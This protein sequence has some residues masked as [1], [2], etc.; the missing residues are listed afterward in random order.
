M[1]A[2]LE[3]VLERAGDDLFASVCD[4]VRAAAWD[5]A[6]AAKRA[7]LRAVA[8][9]DDVGDAAIDDAVEDA[10]Q[11]AEAAIERIFGDYDWTVE[12]EQRRALKSLEEGALNNGR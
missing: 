9:G 10:A 1:S 2:E 12:F 7:I 8:E 6:F 3:T 4:A 5:A 11:D